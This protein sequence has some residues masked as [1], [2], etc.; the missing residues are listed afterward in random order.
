MSINEG[1]IAYQ[2]RLSFRQFVPA[3]L[4]KYGV[5]VWMAADEKMVTSQILLFTSAKQKITAV[6]FTVLATMLS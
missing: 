4:T 6:E 5:K 2:G 3:K 1:M